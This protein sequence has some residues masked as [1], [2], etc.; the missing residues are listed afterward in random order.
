[1]DLRKL[2]KDA[3]VSESVVDYNR[4]A[5]IAIFYGS[6][7]LASQEDAD[8]MVRTALECKLFYLIPN[9][10]LAAGALSPC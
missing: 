3:W 1:V 4:T 7:H 9:T 8:E 10:F 5:E 6:K 2:L